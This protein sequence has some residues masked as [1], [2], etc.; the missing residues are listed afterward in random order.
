MRSR[1]DRDRYRKSTLTY[2]A[3]AVV[4]HLFPVVFLASCSNGT[5]ARDSD[6]V[7]VTY[8]IVD[9]PTV[10]A[11]PHSISE[12]V[13]REDGWCWHW[14]FPV[15]ATL[16]GSHVKHDDGALY[17]SG[18]Y[19]TLMRWPDGDAP[20][21]LGR[22]E[23][24]D[25]TLWTVWVAE[26]NTL[27]CGGHSMSRENPVIY[28]Y[29]GTTLER[30]DI[31]FLD[32]SEIPAGY[33]RRIKSKS[34]DIWAAGS[35]GS[36]PHDDE[37]LIARYSDDEWHEIDAPCPS[38]PVNDLAFDETDCPWFVTA[39]ENLL[40]FDI[41]SSTWNTLTSSPEHAWIR[42]WNRGGILYVYAMDGT[43]GSIDATG[44]VDVIT[45]IPPSFQPYIALPSG[46]PRP[47]LSTVEVDDSAILHAIV[48]D[49]TSTDAIWADA[50]GIGETT[51]LI[52]DGRILWS[53]MDAADGRRVAVGEE[54][55]V[56]SINGT[57]VDVVTRRPSWNN[58]LL[59]LWEMNG[60]VIAVTSSGY[61]IRVQ[62]DAWTPISM[63]PG[64]GDDDFL[65]DLS[66][67]AGD[68]CIYVGTEGRLYRFRDD[69][70]E[71]VDSE[72]D[73]G[74]MIL[75]VCGSHCED[76][77]VITHDNALY[78]LNG[79]SIGEIPQP[80]DEHVSY[81][82][83][84]CSNLGEV[85]VAGSG[86]YKLHEGEW[87]ILVPAEHH[88]DGGWKIRRFVW[89]VEE[90]DTIYLYDDDSTIIFRGEDRESW[91]CPGFECRVTGV[92]GFNQDDV[93]GFSIWGP[94]R[95]GP[96]EWV[97]ATDLWGISTAGS[98]WVQRDG[99]VYMYADG[100]DTG[101]PMS[102]AVRGMTVL[103]EH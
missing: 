98:S 9:T 26:D 99:T 32:S 100:F 22:G 29:D 4:F 41:V 14:P 86:L 31:V 82:S 77:Y 78:H 16:Y 13:C 83:L 72:Y 62:E 38:S 53:L 5:S 11:E 91:T 68:N 96:G 69:V 35:K 23:A 75:D 67:W 58:D 20:S 95:P 27:W 28:S 2:L 87:T 56:V 46:F 101:Y 90:D 48:Q 15:G 64:A 45:T 81:M 76:V 34:N 93:W 97:G 94:I 88:E 66:L 71:L 55:T 54:G 70:W 42:I 21:L 85:F 50:S 3:R 17:M 51:P 7:D 80:V 19:G 43:F 18:G 84:W 39:S 25:S 8:D 74:A 1:I 37:C 33:I 47:I 52:T 103:T 49:G 61:L 6:T 102:D 40:V 44:V 10:D 59:R 12:P 89:G 57:E 36:L 79:E 73:F 30:H 63:L 60:L 92:R 24:S 65:G